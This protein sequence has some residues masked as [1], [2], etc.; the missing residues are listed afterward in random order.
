M[1]AHLSYTRWPPRNI[2]SNPYLRREKSM[3]IHHVGSRDRRNDLTGSYDR[4]RVVRDIDVEGSMHHL[5]CVVR[6]RVLND[7]D[8]ITELGGVA[9]GR[10]D[11]GVR[12]E[13]DDDE[14][15]DVVLLELQV[16]VGVGEA[17]GTPVFLCD[18]LAWCRGEFGTELATPCAVF[19]ALALPRGSLNWRN[20]GPHFI[21]AC[22]I[23]M[24][25]GIEDAKFHCARG[26]QHL[27]HVGNAVVCFGD[28]FDS[29]PELAAL[30]N[31]VVVGVDHQK[32]GDALVM[33]RGI[34]SGHSRGSRIV[35]TW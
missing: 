3:A 23:P 24:M 32:C 7:G 14:L 31:E 17:T 28:S 20:V 5:V 10:F 6:G 12:D 11:A 25:H 22:T 26:I 35:T 29:G 34:H 16:Q 30:G 27:Q 8:V 1:P 15:M 9:H 21:V 2:T 19:E 13:S 18:N 33:C 4:T